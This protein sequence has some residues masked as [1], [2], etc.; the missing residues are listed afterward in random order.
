[1]KRNDILIKRKFYAY[2]LPGVLMVAA[3]QLG[4][5][6][7]SI[8]IGNFLGSEALSASVLGTPVVFLAQVPM[9]VFANGGSAVS[10]IYLGKMEKEKAGRV[11]FL[12]FLFVLLFNLVNAGACFFYSGPVSALLTSDPQL[13]KLTETFLKIY[14]LGMP[15]MGASFV[16]ASFMAI[17]N[18]PGESAALHITA[19]AINLVSEFI[20]MKL[21]GWGIEAAVI[22]TILGYTLSGIV[23]GIVYLRSK[24]RML[25]KTK[26]KTEKPKGLFGETFRTGLPSGLLML[27]SAVKLIVINAAVLTI[28]GTFGMAIYAVSSSSIF[29][30]QLCLNG[31]VGVLQT[32]TGALYGDKD[33]YGIRQLLKRVFLISLGVS[34]VLMAVYLILPQLIAGMF[35]YQITEGV[36]EM[37][38]CLRLLSLSFPFY[39]LNS[40]TQ[41]YYM[42][43]QRTFLSVMN[44][45]IQGLIVLIPATFLFLSLMGVEGS[46]LACV[47]AELLAFAATWV[48][49]VISQKRGKM[50]GND[51]AAIPKAPEGQY[52]D[53]TVEGTSKD[54]SGLAHLL[55]EYCLE[56][57]VERKTAN[58]VGIAGEELVER[59]ASNPQKGK[60]V[61]Y[62]DI[63]LLRNGDELIL[64]VRDDGDLFNPLEAP[65][66]NGEDG[67]EISGLS[68]IRSLAQ[69]ISYSRILNMNNTIVEIG[70]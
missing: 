1:M 4:N 33:F 18:H 59:I 51:F 13:A 36:N 38:V 11:F 66:D 6:V 70:V 15:L 32:M 26:E 25:R 50:E 56:K 5:L 2:L 7:D 24:R 60:S 37:H 48:L 43:I 28:T 20:F 58:A 40:L 9:M 39:A 42:T 55:V 47:A 31:P 65:S 16:L 10:S 8:F 61:S 62:I 67:M 53:L 44:T 12:A 30:V 34:L 46:G 27:L 49:R 22:S 52:L 35:G 57:G 68:L 69:N 54:A 41:T 23:F 64:R 3:L 14:I 63:Y 45:L 19:N 17:D 29:L 21:M